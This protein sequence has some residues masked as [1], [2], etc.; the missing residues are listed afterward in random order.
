M[1]RSFWV[2][3]SALDKLVD[4]EDSQASSYL[5]R[6]S[7]SIVRAVHF[8]RTTPLHLWK[9]QAVKFDQM[10]RKAIEGI[11]GF[12]M[13]DFT[14]M[15]ACLTPK[16]GGLGLRRVAEHADVAYQA[17]WHESQKTA[18]EVW[19][20]PPG[21]SVELKPQSQASF[22]L[23]EKLHAL[24]VSTAPTEREAQRLR[25]VAQPH[26]QRFYHS[27]PVGGRRA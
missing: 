1:R 16:L 19:V 20:A 6:V 21:M 3:F 9:D 23:D 22:E 18:Q 2:D 17:S 25:R 12:P 8:M 5:L 4:F 24:L 10:I 11:L 14:F 27:C 13:S 26:R 7:Y 15:Q